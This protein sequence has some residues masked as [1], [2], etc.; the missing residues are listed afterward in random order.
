MTDFRQQQSL[1]FGSPADISALAVKEQVRILVISDSHGSFSVVRA[2]VQQFGKDCDALCFCGD[3]AQDVLSVFETAACKKLASL[4]PECIPP[5]AAIVRGNGDFESGWFYPGVDEAAEV[6]LPK[7]LLLTAAGK[8]ILLTHGHSYD[9]YYN[10]RGL[11]DA[12]AIQNADIVFFGHTHIA[13]VQEKDAVTLL[14]PGSCSRPRG[15]QP[16]TFA[17]VT[18]RANASP[19]SPACTFGYYQITGDGNTFS[20]Q[21]YLPHTG[22]FNLLW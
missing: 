12:A 4:P 3:G 16:H 21:P 18:L 5:V 7:E 6:S 15:G 2:I 13:N 9:V 20:F 8:R 17:I 19:E 22:E 1:L 10:S 11:Y 14:N